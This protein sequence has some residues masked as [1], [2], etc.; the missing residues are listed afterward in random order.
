MPEQ[1]DES[2]GRIRAKLDTL[3]QLVTSQAHDGEISNPLKLLQMNLKYIL[4]NSKDIKGRCS[5]VS[6]SDTSLKIFIHLQ[7]FLT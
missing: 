7:M 4:F 6:S 5:G 2:M 3:A 1:N